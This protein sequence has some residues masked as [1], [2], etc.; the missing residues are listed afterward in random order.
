MLG[1]TRSLPTCPGLRGQ[2]YAGMSDHT[3]RCRH[4]LFPPR[5]CCPI[6]N[7]ADK[8]ENWNIKDDAERRSLGLV[9]RMIGRDDDESQN[10]LRSYLLGLAECPGQGTRAASIVTWQGSSAE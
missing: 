2:I 10:D 4:A 6:D 3:G 7:E 5:P 1:T 8:G 9:R